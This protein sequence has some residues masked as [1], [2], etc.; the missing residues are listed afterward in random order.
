MK[1]QP[2]IAF[3]G[4]CEEALEFYTKSIGADKFGVPWMV[5]VDASNA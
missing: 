2:Y 4:R 3:T 1:V 5:N